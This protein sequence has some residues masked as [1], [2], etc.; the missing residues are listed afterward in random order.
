MTVSDGGREGDLEVDAVVGD[1]RMMGA[2]LCRVQ[3]SDGSEVKAVIDFLCVGFYHPVA[4]PRR[5]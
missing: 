4:S 2:V 3:L 1:D 5:Q